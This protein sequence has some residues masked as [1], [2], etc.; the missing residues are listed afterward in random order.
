MN[1]RLLIIAFVLSFAL[2]GCGSSSNSV[3]PPTPTDGSNNGGNLNTGNGVVCPNGAPSW[4]CDGSQAPLFF[5]N[6]NEASLNYPD[7][8]NIAIGR[9]NAI[10][11][12]VPNLVSDARFSIAL[13]TTPSGTSANKVRV[14]FEDRAGWYAEEVSSFPG[15]TAWT[16][17]T[18]GP[19]LDT[20][21]SDLR[22]TF[23]VF[24]VLKSTG[25]VD[26]NIYYRLR[27]PGDTQ[28]ETITCNGTAQ[29][30]AMYPPPDTTV[31][32]KSYMSTGNSA[33]Q[34]LGHVD[35]VDYS[36]WLKN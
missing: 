9:P 24:A 5:G 25:L 6:V 30:C 33:V 21:N 4:A 18:L 26:A 28:C 8:A 11:P 10:T 23:R 16:L 1:R 3:N 20:I 31:P 17:S 35:N 15:D 22:I 32:C 2:V 14:S 7:L 36:T 27:Q 19:A 29:Q 12:F 34:Y 13:G